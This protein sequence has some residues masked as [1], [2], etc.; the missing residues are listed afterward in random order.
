VE[1]EPGSY[2]LVFELFGADGYSDV[3]ERRITVAAGETRR[4]EVPLE[5]PGEL[6]VQPHLHSPGGLL[7]ANGEA[8]GTTPVRR[9]KMRPG[10][11]ELTVTPADGG[12]GV[13]QTV[14]IRSGAHT[15]VTVDLTG[16]RE[17]QVR[18]LEPESR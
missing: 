2:V 11:Y 6:S 16:R 18:T 14:Q 12:Q 4:I 10:S 15:I 17:T 8:L 1:L 7:V 3:K 5:R 9:R 13:T